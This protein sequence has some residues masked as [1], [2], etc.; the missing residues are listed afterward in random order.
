MNTQSIP[1]N[2]VSYEELLIE[3]LRDP[4]MAELYREASWEAF[5]DDNDI[6]ALM[7][8]YKCL[9]QAQ[10]HVF[11]L[12]P[13]TNSNMPNGA[14]ICAPDDNFNPWAEPAHAELFD[15]IDPAEVISSRV[16][17]GANPAK[18]PILG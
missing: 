18:A 17:L 10:H 8:A 15:Q 4:H 14:I 3:K 1:K 12:A 16:L 7:F 2:T 13:H 6:E 9:E 11:C 5:L